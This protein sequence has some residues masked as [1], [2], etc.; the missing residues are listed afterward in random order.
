M[1]IDPRVGMYMSIGLAV[2]GVLGGFSDQFTTV[3]GAH[4]TAIILAVAYMLMTVGNAVNGV[5][6]AIPSKSTPAALASFPLGPG[7]PAK[8][9]EAN[10]KRSS[11]SAIAIF[12]LAG[13]LLMI[14]AP[15]ARAA[16]LAAPVLKAPPNLL[17]G[18]VSGGCGP[19]FGLNTMGSAGSVDG[20]PPG[21]SVIQGDVGV[22]VGYGCPIGTTPGNF[23]FVEG[24]FDW[25]N[26]NGNQNGF[27]MTGP[28][29][30]EQRVGFGSP[31][32][33]MLNMFPGFSS[34][35]SVPSLP[36][37]PAGVTQGPSYPFL[38]VSAHEQDVSAQFG[39]DQNQQWLFAP[40]IG[41]GLESRLSNGVVADMAAQWVMQSNG[42][43]VGPA[44]VHMG[45][46]ALVSFT[47]KY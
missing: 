18:Y 38:F 39:L 20:G 19:Y 43:S 31:I 32:S 16:D 30:F 3:F 11:T 6:H 25:A 34:G 14:L 37:L 41:I 40:G 26:I 29:H 4:A 47:L 21:A 5:L 46:A 12:I 44:T 2:I 35:L 8:L 45:N 27:S 33:S 17:T 23:W 13:L 28:A 24:N 1:T 10:V 7:A 15:G 9:P 22:T 42:L 36:A